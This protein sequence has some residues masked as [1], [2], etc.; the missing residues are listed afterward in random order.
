MCANY[1]CLFTVQKR[2]HDP[3]GVNEH[4]GLRQRQVVR[5]LVAPVKLPMPAYQRH[6]ES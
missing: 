3:L 4:L 6:V 1:P 5:S 2:R